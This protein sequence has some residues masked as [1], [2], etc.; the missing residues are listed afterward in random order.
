MLA[1][2]GSTPAAST[3]PKGSEILRAL[4]F[5]CD[6]RTTRG[7]GR[8]C[9]GWLDGRRA[10]NGRFP[11]QSRL[12]SPFVLRVVA[13]ATLSR[14]TTYTRPFVVNHGHQSTGPTGPITLVPIEIDDKGNGCGGE[15]RTVRIGVVD[16]HD[17]SRREVR[18]LGQ[19][20]RP[21]VPPVFRGDYRGRPPDQR[22]L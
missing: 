17:Q 6:P 7:S 18:G 3:N 20:P 5:V 21:R 4:L 19:L 2:A 22:L 15:E 10:G 11:C 14:S 9:C 16:A 13:A 12:H 8:L 1:D